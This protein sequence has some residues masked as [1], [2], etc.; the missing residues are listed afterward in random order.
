ML[1]PASAAVANTDIAATSLRSIA[2]PNNV[3]TPPTQY[4]GRDLL[5]DN[6]L[7]DGVNGLSC[8]AWPGYDRE[9][10]DDFVVPVEWQVT[11]GEY[12]VLTYSGTT[13][14]Q[15][16]I[17]SFF[18]DSGGPSTTEY[19]SVTATITCT[20]TGDIYFSR[21]EVLVSCSFDTVTLSPGTWWV[22]FQS[23]HT[24]NVFTL[25]APVQGSPVYLSFPDQ[26][27]PRWTPGSTVFGVDYDMAWLLTGTAGPAEDTTPPVTH[28]NFT[29]TNPVTVTITASDDDS[30]VNHTYYKLDAAAW[31]EYTSPFQVSV[32]GDHTLMCYSVDKAGNE[33]VHHYCNFTVEAPAITITIKGGLGV[34][35]TIKNT[36][37]ANLTNISWSITLDGKLVFVG[38]SKTGTIAALAPGDSQV[39]KDLLVIGFGKTGIA[40][41]AAGVE[42]SATG[43]VILFLVIGVK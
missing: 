16:T 5:Y 34:S 6:G 7:P 43:T 13:S 8:G 15:G 2:E 29:G 22:C 20:P 21:P 24:E 1:I 19:A 35:A 3:V 42:E 31:A 11:G 27:Y 39:V 10:I 14:I 26:A 18:Q 41:E 38:K 12:R 4:A 36:G 28:C 25:T 23:Q 17:V 33:E 32:P 40:V 37:T 9:I 30:G